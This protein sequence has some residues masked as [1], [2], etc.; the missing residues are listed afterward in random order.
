VSSQ[1]SGDLPWSGGEKRG[2]CNGL[3][4]SVSLLEKVDTMGLGGKGEGQSCGVCP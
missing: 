2:Q 3:V 4:G 1:N